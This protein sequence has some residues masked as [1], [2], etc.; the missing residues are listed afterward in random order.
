LHTQPL[1]A[2]DLGLAGADENAPTP[3]PRTLP[4]GTQITWLMPDIVACLSFV[5]TLPDPY[6]AAAIKLLINEGSY[7]PED[8]PRYYH[9]R[10]EMMKGMQGIVAHGVVSPHIDLT[11]E[12]GDGKETLGRRD[13]SW[14][15]WEYA[16]QV[17]F[18]LGDASPIVR[19]PDANESGGAAE[20][21][22]ASDELPPDAR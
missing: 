9:H 21:A 13:L 7:A 1:T 19:A 14:A 20:P 5:G 4:S 16:Y 2:R 15:D 8:D 6:T 22:P 11:R 18:R 10:L 17:L 12:W 3:V